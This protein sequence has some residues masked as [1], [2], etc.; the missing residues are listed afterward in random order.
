MRKN[1]KLSLCT[2]ILIATNAYAQTED[3]GMITVSGATKSEQSIQD[4]TSN[5]KIIEAVE[6]EEKN[7]NTISD[8]LNLVNGISFTS[9]G[10]IGATSSI[11][12]RGMGNNRTLVLIDGTRL[13]D[14]SNTS[15]TNIGHL[16]VTDIEKIEI[17]K[18][19]QSGIW[20][21]DA[22][23][24]VINI[25]TK[26]AQKGTHGNIHAEY[27]SFNTKKY[28]TS[29]SHKETKYD[30]KLNAQ[31][32]TSDS[33]SSQAPNG[34]DIDNYEDD[35]YENT[36]LGLKANYYINDDAKIGVNIL[37]IDAKKEYDG[38]A[39]KDTDTQKAN[40]RSF[41]SDTKTKV[42]AL[43]YQQKL[44]NHTINVKLEKSDFE[45]DELG[46]TFG[47]K[48]F[49]GI[50]NN[51]EVNDLFQYSK[52]DF[53][54]FGTGIND[55]D[56]DYVKVDDT[57]SQ[58][59]NKDKYLYITNSNKFSNTILTQSV[60]YDNYNNYDNKLTGK[61][62]LKHNFSTVGYIS[63]NIGTA[64]NSPSII[65]SLN[66]WGDSN[67]DLNPENSKSFDISM[68]YK[69]FKITGYYTKII[70]LISWEASKYQNL[71]GESTFKGIELDY[72]KMVLKDTL[73]TLNYARV[74]A[75]DE[76][77]KD[78]KRRA[79]QT[80]KFSLDYYGIEKLHLGLHGEYVGERFDDL[81]KTKQTGRYTVANLTAN[82]D[83]NKM[84]K[85]YGKIDNITNKY[86]QTT[87]GYTT[88][89]RAYYAG[90]KVS[91]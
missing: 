61:I 20:G 89:P 82:Y 17:I 71:T 90:V 1:I 4:V 26:S 10:G 68:K 51:L 62:G 6:L 56:V 30:I 64:Y 43:N 15:G 3:L 35:K 63:T 72:S 24:G 78:L 23:A 70:D 83:I 81:A 22:S 44:N 42:Y 19:A 33:F 38:G 49:N 52:N 2:A 25:I 41:A 40:N 80:L 39:W 29:L 50:H 11:T 53:L 77:K 16:V 86:Y 37:T 9:N 88:S 67:P 85:I 54:I 27:G 55:D 58:K 76:D 47:V 5:I 48:T 59:K 8:V 87:D 91:F 13:Q 31:K 79:K 84:V 74:S 34:K 7:I 36:T 66:P 46:S 65:Q 14:P 21:A 73:F 75:K 60:R 12:M 28:G 69:D 32:I 45:R 18:G 57:M